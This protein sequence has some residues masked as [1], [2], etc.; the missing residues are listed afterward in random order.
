MNL[1]QYLIVKT[2]ISDI[3]DEDYTV[4]ALVYRF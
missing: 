1:A 4:Y 3:T 2:S